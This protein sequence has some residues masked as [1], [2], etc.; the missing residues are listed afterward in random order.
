MTNHKTPFL[1]E[2]SS[3][4]HW[5]GWPPAQVSPQGIALRPVFGGQQ[6]SLRFDSVPSRDLLLVVTLDRPLQTPPPSLL[7]VSVSGEKLKI[8][9]KKEVPDCFASVVRLGAHTADGL[10]V[11]FCSEG[12]AGQNALLQIQ[13]VA[14]LSL[15]SARFS[16]RWTSWPRAIVSL[17]R[18]LKKMS[19]S[20]ED[21]PYSHFDGVSYLLQHHDV[22]TS[23]LSR[24]VSSAYHFFVK[25]GRHLGHRLP[26]AIDRD[27]LPGTPFNFVTYY[28]DRAAED[29]ARSEQEKRETESRIIEVQ[30]ENELL[31]LQLHTVQ[32]ELEH[33]FLKNKDLESE[34]E[35]L[36]QKRDTLATEKKA[37]DARISTLESEKKTLVSEKDALAKERDALATEKS[38]L[39][40]RHQ[41][42]AT[43]REALSARL[44]TLDSEKKTL[45]SEKEAL[46]AERDTI[47]TRLTSLIA[48]HN[49]LAK[50]SHE[51]QTALEALRKEIEAGKAKAA[52]TEKQC[53][54][55]V[56]QRDAL[57]AEKKAL[58]ARFSTLDSEKKT[59]VSE[60]DALAAERDTIS[61]RLT[62]LIADHNELAKLSHERQT[63][64]EALRKE[65]EAGKAKAAE[66]EK[67]CADLVAQRDAL[68]AEKK[69]LDARLSTLD[70][71]KK[72]LVSEKDALAK[73]RDQLKKS[74]ADRA[75]R[76]AELEAQVADQ[77]E[78]Q[79]LIDEQMVRAE[80]QL[81]MLKEFLQPAFQ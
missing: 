35:S 15:E 70:S 55:L 4:E 65:I 66:T 2:A 18:G 14:V 12:T 13:S 60:K 23:V 73:E 50:L 67:Q 53:A 40:T 30:E 46:A 20:F 78:R 58:D 24:K 11:T 36:A 68:A 21:F 37:L 79:K 34:R 10:S 41:Q 54:D 9:W 52:E 25:H 28:R 16:P 44:S 3:G 26:L 6:S 33:Y 32:E 80:T 61:T 29:V 57:A 59:L 63:A 1:V 45:V 49:E 48:D 74:A 39:A 19:W 51:R 62:S 5:D 8:L 71:E 27:P 72:T 17:L 31:L 42:L 22:R 75:A 77:A 43:E 69:A 7:A 47:S 64:L 81:E 38:E 76:I 56:A